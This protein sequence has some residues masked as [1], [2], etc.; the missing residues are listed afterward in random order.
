VRAVGVSINDHDPDS[1][2]E[3]VRSRPADAVQ[4]IRNFYGE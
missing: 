3:L 2:L 1:A 4:V